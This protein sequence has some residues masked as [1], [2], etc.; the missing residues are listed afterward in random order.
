MRR[1]VLPLLALLP[2]A[3]ALAAE[4]DYTLAC[5]R[6]IVDARRATSRPAGAPI[7]AQ[8]HFTGTTTSRT[9]ADGGRTRY[10]D[11][12]LSISGSR[13]KGGAVEGSNFDNS[14]TYGGGFDRTGEGST[15]WAFSRDF[16]AFT[17]R[18][19]GLWYVCA[20]T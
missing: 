19:G 12:V 15:D 16:R 14:T 8:V 17:L 1:I 20:R 5:G 13:T 11:F 4:S 9:E 7:S 18:H 10:A 6:E 2:A 3:A